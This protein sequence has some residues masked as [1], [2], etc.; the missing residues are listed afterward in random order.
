MNS[1][2]VPAWASSDSLD[3]TPPA[4]S[5]TS[6]DHTCTR[7]SLK[8][9]IATLRP[10]MNRRPK[11]IISRSDRPAKPPVRIIRDRP[12]LI[13]TTRLISRRPGAP[14]FR[15]AGPGFHLRSAGVSVTMRELPVW[16]AR[17]RLEHCFVE[18]V[19][20]RHSILALAVLLA[21][22]VSLASADYI[23]IITNVG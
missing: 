13:R 1:R 6:L 5:A 20:M 11:P 10:R 4:W 19:G 7:S 15:A 14:F 17:P 3:D 12:G 16:R 21:G 22:A 18:V 9:M 23:V 2:L 8:P